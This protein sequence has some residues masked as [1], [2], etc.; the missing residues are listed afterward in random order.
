MADSPLGRTLLIANPA[1][2]SGKGAAGAQ[3]AERFLGSYASVTDGY[4]IR[5][6]GRPRR[7]RGHGRG[8]G[9]L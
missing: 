5:L 2:H 6:T 8:R 3:F 1:A 4:E 7:G 9:R